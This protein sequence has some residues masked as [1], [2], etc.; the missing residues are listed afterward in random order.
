MRALMGAV[1]GAF[2]A[3]SVAATNDASHPS[4]RGFNLGLQQSMFPLLGLALGP[5][6]ATR[7]LHIVSWRWVFA[8]VAVPGLVLA[9]ILARVIREPRRAPVS[10]S[11]EPHPSL[12]QI[13]QHRN[14]AVAMLALLCAMSG[15][16]T[17]SAMVPTYLTDYRHL[18]A[19][20][21]GLVT[22]AIGFG[23]FSGQVLLPGASDRVGRRWVAWFGFGGAALSV[24]A[25]AAS[26]HSIAL[27]FVSLFVAAFFCCGLVGLLTGPVA[28]EAAPPG[29]T[30]TT[31]G[32][33][34]GAGEI[35]GGGVAP[36]LAG[37]IAQHFG[38]QHTLT[39]ACCGLSIGLVVS[40]FLIETAPSRIE[41]RNPMSVMEPEP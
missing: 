21:M 27:L 37:N 20:Q 7:L 14:V 18:G 36:S 16:F 15:L 8:L 38:I 35:F 13:F 9:F 5:I 28:T 30:S 12:G 10:R 11:D 32:L 6:I 2:C 1:E 26:P 23:G 39:M 29:L 19:D 22:S 31:A 33:I 34:I 24:Y 17:L 41:A 25:F 4:R 40:A 3:T